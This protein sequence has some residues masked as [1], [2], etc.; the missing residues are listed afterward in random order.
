[1][2]TG[3][4]CGCGPLDELDDE[5]DE[6]ED[7][8]EAGC[9][10][11]HGWTATVCVSVPGGITIVFEPSGMS[12]LPVWTSRGAVTFGGLS[13]GRGQ[14][15]ITIVIAVFCLPIRTVRVPG[16]ISAIDRASDIELLDELLLPPQPATASA[17]QTATTTIAARVRPLAIRAISSLPLPVPASTSGFPRPRAA[18]R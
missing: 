14:G 15:G 12:A 2:L 16:V 17:A 1:M 8:D 9:D 18:G 7:E 11:W 6:E 5:D 4:P 3:G 13:P 10:G